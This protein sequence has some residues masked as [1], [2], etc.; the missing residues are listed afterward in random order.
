MLIRQFIVHFKVT[1]HKRKDYQVFL[2]RIAPSC[3][4]DALF[5]LNGSNGDV[6]VYFICIYLPVSLR[7][8]QDVI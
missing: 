8:K 4:R 5:R 2:H 6:S 1:L 7:L 3:V